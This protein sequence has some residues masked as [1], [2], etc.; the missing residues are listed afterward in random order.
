MSS[1]SQALAT[2]NKLLDELHATGYYPA[3]QVCVRHRG[4]IV[5]DRAIGQYRPIEQDSWRPVTSQTRF[6]LFS[7]SKCV[8]A[9]CAHILF[10]RGLIHVDDPIHWT[11]PEFA[12]HGKEHITLRHVLT[13]TA[14]IPMLRWKLT[15]ALI[16]DWDRIIRDLCESKPL[17]F[18]GR[19]TG[20]HLLSG[21]YIL[22]EVIRRVDGRTLREFAQQELLD[23]L[24]F[25]TFNFG[26]SADWY[27][28]T[29]KSERV[30]PLPPAPLLQAMNQVLQLDLEQTLAVMNRPAVFESVI[31]S[32]NIVGTAEET[33]RFFQMLLNGGQLD[34]ARVLSEQQV[35]RATIEQVV[36][37]HDLTLLLMPARYSL[38]FMLGRKRSELNVFGKDTAQAFGHLGFTRN[39]GW[40]DP[41]RSLA[42]GFLTSSKIT[43]PRQETLILR[44]FQNAINSLV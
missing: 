16:M 14:G 12:Q 37:K 3:L 25:E 21:G 33:S 20:Y 15:D 2:A 10:D 34:G 40:A 43:Y 42:V 8:A 27:E 1:N 35:K 9:V 6:M 32:G 26:I 11:I 31:P 23:P 22:G 39:L 38:G 18:P 13:H 30:D 44:R 7:I 5:L 4:Q 29:A 17:Y 19:M 36:A 41:A 24:G 28:R